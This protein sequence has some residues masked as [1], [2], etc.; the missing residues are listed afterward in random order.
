[1]KPLGVVLLQSD[2]RILRSLAASLCHHFHTIH[3]VHNM[4]ELR[5]LMVKH[6]TQLAIIDME[7]ACL[8]EIERLHREFTG[9][10]IVCTHRLADEEM[11]TAA[12]NAGAIDVCPSC[13]TVSIVAAACSLTMQHSAAA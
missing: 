5:E 1:M 3:A 11:W 2:P 10:S 7:M 9:V 8:S 6:T 12:L 4:S 13:D